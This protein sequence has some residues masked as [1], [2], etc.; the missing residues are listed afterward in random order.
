MVQ[1]FIKKSIVTICL[2]LSIL[3][4]GYFSLDH[5][6]NEFIPAIEVPAVGVVFPTTF[7]PHRRITEELIG[8]IE[9]RLL[10]TGDVEKIETTLDR[11]RTILFIFYKWSIRP[12]DCL[13]RARQVV[14]GV[15][16]PAGIL[17][18]IFVLHR[19][20]MSPIFRIAFTGKNVNAL[21]QDLTQFS[22]T[23]ERIPGVAGVNLVGSAPMKAVV[24]MDALSGA[25]NQ[26]AASDVI[27]SAI[28]Q[29]SFRYLFRN[30]KGEKEIFRLHLKDVND[31]KSLPVQSKSGS[32]VPLRW[33][34]QVE[35]THSP[36]SVFFGDG[37]DAVIL[38]VMKAPGSD[39]LLIVDNV[40]KGIKK[41]SQEKNL[42]YTI[43]YDE[44]EK[45]REAQA[46]VIQN[47]VIGVGLNSL[48]L[49][50]F[51]GSIIGA[52]VASC[53]FPTAILG[54][55]YVMKA[56]DIS[57]NIFALNGFSLASGMITDSSIVVLESIM[58]RFQKGEDL[59]QS[60]ARGTKDVMIGVLASTLT[61]AAVIVP[62]SMQTGV[63]SKLFSDLG[64]V[65]VATQFICL[66]AVFTFVP[67]LCSRIL[68]DDK[69]RPA[70]I[71]IL[72]GLSSRLV[73]RMLQLSTVTLKKSVKERGFRWGLPLVATMGSLLMMA[74]LPNSEFL[75]VVSSKIYSISMPVKRIELM[76]KGSDLQ[77]QLAMSL[78]TNEA[79]NWVVTSRSDD[80]LNSVLRVKNLKDV[81]GIIEKISQDLN[82]PRKKIL[83]LPL[84]PT[85][86]TEPM[87]YDGYFYINKN[88]PPQQLRSLTDSFC[89][90]PGIMDC[91]T[92][93]HYQESRLQLRPRPLDMFRSHT[94]LFA[95]MADI[96]SL[97]QNLN[98]SSLANLPIAFPVELHLPGKELL[99]SF[100]LAT[101]GS[102]E[103]ISRLGAFFDSEI[104][105]SSNVLFR[106]D[107]QNFIPLYFRLNGITIGQAVAALEGEAKAQ[108]IDSGSLI[109]MGAIETMNETFGKMINAL[110][111]AAVLI[112]LVLV[113]Q[114]RSALQAAI[115]MYSIPLSLGGA[116]AGLII[117][118]ETL[119]VGVIVGFVLLIGIVVNNGILL[120][121]AINQRRT[122]GMPL[123][124][125]VIDGVDSRT[126]PILMTTFSTVFGMMPTLVLEAEGKELYRGMAIVNVFG[127][128]FGTFLTL[129]V[130]PIVIR[131]LIANQGEKSAR[132]KGVAA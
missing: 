15:S 114:F 106:R 125:A 71:A 66:I 28:Q 110:I 36:A 18:P 22:R 40:L 25:Q 127:M 32:Q 78:G 65:L 121:D 14:S 75:P 76:E 111:L 105:R 58:R 92:A 117:L 77:K 74:F 124:E 128:I 95:T 96:A 79:V 56:S 38:E 101:G 123:L 104:N 122:A 29:W 46:G 98:L 53:V 85:P 44:A 7:V 43:L 84:G 23:A 129:V 10:A 109:P 8:P 48:I 19:P 120:M 30:D 35:E 6:A 26:V 33:I 3:L 93:S 94:N 113:I 41:L 47:F 54:T 20:T 70:P 31:L 119:N 131:A 51:L 132:K 62:I 11:D 69:S 13:Q 27:S 72:Y 49:I 4:I 108:G 9:K 64:I 99:T 97:T 60:A 59:V 67:W 115:I 34:S 102:G 116:I 118:G 21:T 39:A 2:N 126:R 83:A 57:L 68:S 87:G 82:F 89:Q 12:E 17:E 81:P 42:N 45:I 1:Y 103:G 55:L 91:T 88:L 52:V 100:P 37:Q 5:I 130:T 50:I 80:T 63:S 86:P 107:G 90:N 112:F 16:R 73:D 61:T 24:E